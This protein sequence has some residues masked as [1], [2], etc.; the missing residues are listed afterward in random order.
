M[1]V[2]YI[3]CISE[4]FSAFSSALIHSYWII[5]DNRKLFAS[6]VDRDGQVVIMMA[7]FVVYTIFYFALEE[8]MLQ[9]IV[10]VEIIICAQRLKYRIICCNNQIRCIYLPT[11]IYKDLG[12]RP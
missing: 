2:L 6:Y 10:Q 12:T 1:N 7:G 4:R 3:E 9:H 11:N 8:V 5:S